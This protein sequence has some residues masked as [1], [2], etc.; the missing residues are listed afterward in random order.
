[1]KRI[2][3]PVETN[4][5]LTG[6][7]S[8][9]NIGLVRVAP[10]CTLARISEL[11]RVDDKNDHDHAIPS[12]VSYIQYYNNK[13]R[14]M[15]CVRDA[16][17]NVT[18]SIENI[19]RYYEWIGMIGILLLC[20]LYSIRVTFK[21]IPLNASPLGRIFKESLENDVF[22]FTG[23][24]ENGAAI[25]LEEIPVMCVNGEPMAFVHQSILL[26]P[27]KTYNK[28]ALENVQWFN[29]RVTVQSINGINTSTDESEWVDLKNVLTADAMGNNLS[30][31][32]TLFDQCLDR[33]ILSR[34]GSDIGQRLTMVK[35]YFLEREGGART[36]LTNL[37]PSELSV[38]FLGNDDFELPQG[39]NLSVKSLSSITLNN[40]VRGPAL[41]EK[42]AVIN[43]GNIPNAIQCQFT[44][45]RLY[46]TNTGDGRETRITILPP[47]TKELIIRDGEGSLEIVRMTYDVNEL[48]SQNEKTIKVTMVYRVNDIPITFS[49]E[50]R[51][52]D[53]IYFDSFPYLSVWPFV[54]LDEDRWQYY[55]VGIFKNSEIGFRPNFLGR[56]IQELESEHI[57][58]NVFEINN[59]NPSQKENIQSIINP[60]RTWEVC[61]T[62]KRVKFIS[63]KF[64]DPITHNSEDFGVLYIDYKDAISPEVGAGDGTFRIGLDF[65][66]TNTNCYGRTGAT[67]S[68][69]VPLYGNYL[70]AITKEPSIEEKNK[71]RDYC[72]ITED[73]VDSENSMIFSTAQIFNRPNTVNHQDALLDGKILF[74]DNEVLT[75]LSFG[76]LSL[77][78]QGIFVNLKFGAAANAQK[79]R[80]IFLKQ[81]MI[82]ALLMGRLKG[83]DFYEIR[84]AYPYQKVFDDLQTQWSNIFLND[85]QGVVGGNF[86]D[87][88]KMNEASAVGEYFRAG[89]VADTDASSGIID[90]GGG[91]TDISIW[92]GVPEPVNKG[93]TSIKYAGNKV[94]S[95]SLFQSTNARFD[96]T[97]MW[98]SEDSDA[99]RERF[100]ERVNGVDKNI[101]INDPCYLELQNILNV[102]LQREDVDFTQVL[103]QGNQ[104]QRLIAT[105][106][107]RYT[108]LFYLYANLLKKESEANKINLGNTHQ[109]KL[110]GGGVNGL[111]FCIGNNDLRGFNQSAFGRF[112]LK[113]IK[114]VTGMDEMYNLDITLTNSLNK[115][116]VVR[117][118]LTAKI[119]DNEEIP[120]GNPIEADIVDDTL[121]ETITNEE[122]G[123]FRNHLLDKLEEFK[124]L[125]NLDAPLFR[126]DAQTNMIDCINFNNIDM[127]K[128]GLATNNLIENGSQISMNAPKCI[129]DECHLV[130]YMD[131]VLG[132]YFQNGVRRC[133]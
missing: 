120:F 86:I 109:I 95:R 110:V 85:L 50:Y 12:P 54:N 33:L 106:R 2:L 100:R 27:F 59:D 132:D 119:L 118:I 52:E 123:D 30:P 108:L 128:S 88:R 99:L 57:S 4:D 9:K 39:I 73:C 117:G 80:N 25:T 62:K 61:N 13:I 35:N 41:T 79:A 90:I 126:I 87:L 93:K 14:R 44:Y 91:T 43:T 48:T 29:Y 104:Y 36:Q 98:N 28:K 115:E 130:L 60:I 105:M 97:Q 47:V 8:L 71:I 94:I 49:K 66:T 113:L 10:E 38:H 55:Q 3:L 125:L 1:M 19:E 53:I 89:I 23:R 96:I 133:V 114:K 74:L 24:I 84:L 121:I 11:F 83:Q 63:C 92:Q 64:E 22:F 75:N 127:I 78:G 72:W 46:P 56:G 70:R 15:S 5:E 16:N 45:S 67:D 20:E 21:S 131:Y 31:I 116:E 102:L 18:N 58:F 76:N 81:L 77:E 122:L 112:I 40:G 111:K 101:D 32:G 69:P 65:G 6:I 107:L 26:C 34:E 51:D 37:P 103:L 129:V 42:I 7:T 68:E 124:I 82:N 17:G